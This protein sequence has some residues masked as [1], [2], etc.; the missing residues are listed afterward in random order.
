MPAATG[1]ALSEAI[2]R[3]NF[4]PRRVGLRSKADVGIVGARGFP[5]P[6][7]MERDLRPHAEEADRRPLQSVAR[8]LESIIEDQREFRRIVDERGLLEATR[9]DRDEAVDRAIAARGAE[10]PLDR[11]RDGQTQVVAQR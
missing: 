11:R 1:A 6:R 7:A 8:L 4:E 3:G 9:G 5:M 2:D 10:E